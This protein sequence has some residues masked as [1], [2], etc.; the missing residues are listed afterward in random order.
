MCSLTRWASFAFVVSLGCVTPSPPSLER[1]D[2]SLDG[3]V[4]ATTTVDAPPPVDRADVAVD[5]ERPAPLRV[6]FVGNSYT[7]VNDLPMTLTRMASRSA[8][9]GQGPTIETASVTVGG[10]TLRN[11]WETGNAARAITDMGPWSAVVLQ[12]QSVE[13]LLNPTEFRTYGLRF[14]RVIHDANARVVYYATWPRR[15]GDSVYTQ[16]WSGG[17]PEIMAMRLVTTY[18]SVAAMNQDEVARVGAVWMNALSAHPTIDLYDPDGSHPSLAGTYLA[19]CVI[20]R[21]LVGDAPHADAD[22]ASGLAVETARD[23]RAV[24]ATSE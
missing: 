9:R 24:C 4:D 21:A 17:R 1:P 7:Y 14:S 3:A 22:D 10:A 20:Y 15:M 23:L 19:A 11:H 8:A 16:P 12:G 18:E 5:R 6:L 13:P 2:A